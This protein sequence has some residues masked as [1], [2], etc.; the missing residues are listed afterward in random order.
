MAIIMASSKL[1]LVLFLTLLMT[2]GMQTIDVKSDLNYTRPGNWIY[3]RELK[4]TVVS[5]IEKIYKEVTLPLNITIRVRHD[6]PD[7]L[8]RWGKSRI[9]YSLDSGLNF[10]LEDATFAGWEN[11]DGCYVVSGILSGITAGQHTIDVYAEF[12]YGVLSFVNRDR[13][14]LSAHSQVSFQVEM[15]DQRP[16]P[17]DM[18]SSEPQQTEQEIV[19]GVA[20]AVVVI[21]AGLGLLIHL[22]KRK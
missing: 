21:G 5:P 18:R 3:P 22:I 17:S 6:R 9:G 11:E 2:F 4:I 15:P 16:S 14:V 19:I 12:D 20:I 1:S 10:T 8:Y 13:I 7:A